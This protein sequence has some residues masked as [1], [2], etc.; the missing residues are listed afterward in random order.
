VPRGEDP[1][2]IRTE[3]EVEMKHIYDEV[4]GQ[5][6]DFTRR[7]IAHL[8]F[9]KGRLLAQSEENIPYYNN[10]AIYLRHWLMA[11]IDGLIA[12]CRSVFPGS[13]HGRQR[14]PATW[15]SQI[16]GGCLSKF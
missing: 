3:L 13:E 10:E 1:G 15:R 14:Y 4:P 9:L 5:Y 16:L 2:G 6:W 12:E 7:I 8:H 11:A